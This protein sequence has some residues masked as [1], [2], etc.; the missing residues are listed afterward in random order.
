MNST[1][2]T[3][4]L[5]AGASAAAVP[6]VAQ[7]TDRIRAFI[8]YLGRISNERDFVKRDVSQFYY[9]EY[10]WLINGID[11]HKSPDY[12]ARFLG[13]TSE[14]S[15]NRVELIRLK[16]LLSLFFIFEQSERIQGGNYTNHPAFSYMGSNHLTPLPPNIQKSIDTKIDPRYRVF[17][18]NLFIDGG[19]RTLPPHINI[20]TWNYDIQLELS[21][22]EFSKRSLE[23]INRTLQVVPNSNI[24]DI[25]LTQFSIVK[26]NGTA[27]LFFN[28]TNERI[29]ED[30]SYFDGSS[31]NWFG[32][33]ELYKGMIQSKTSLIEWP[34]FHF[35]WER[36]IYT[37]VAQRTAQNILLNTE[38]LIAIGYSFPRYNKDL[39]TGLFEEA[40]DLKNIIVQVQPNEEKEIEKRIR[41][42]LPNNLSNIII[43]FD[44]NL[45]EFHTI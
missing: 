12:F 20:I 7:F 22:N 19:A 37:K 21:Y 43:E 23:I 33:L 4:F 2:I 17:W 32:I 26:L 28:K 31:S 6:T 8:H 35:S 14:D 11:A 38:T 44:N 15:K 16:L 30:A 40:K 42:I 1:K 45:E 5:G 25:D 18:Q 39:D 3:Y 10:Q 34:H 36:N 27:G 13:Q 29:I 24:H 9:S 41:T